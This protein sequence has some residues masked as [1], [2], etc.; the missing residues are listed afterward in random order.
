MALSVEEKQLAL[1]DGQK[2]ILFVRIEEKNCAINVLRH[3]GN[4]DMVME[5]GW[6]PE[7]SKQDVLT[8]LAAKTAATAK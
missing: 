8:A 7:A 5:S 6:Y 1:P 3:D 4:F 2:T